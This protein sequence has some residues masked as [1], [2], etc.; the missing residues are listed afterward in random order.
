MSYKKI[1]KSAKQDLKYYC[2]IAG[3]QGIKEF[4][5]NQQL[6]AGK[7]PYND[8]QNVLDQVMYINK[9]KNTYQKI[10]RAR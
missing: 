6:I 8:Y 5:K 2:N 3:V 10:L 7:I 4:R 9:L 1:L